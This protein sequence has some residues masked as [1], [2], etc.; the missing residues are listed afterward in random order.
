MFGFGKNLLYYPEDRVT[1]QLTFVKLFKTILKCM[2]EGQ[3]FKDI[4]KEICEWKL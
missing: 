2:P 4:V 1:K 3:E